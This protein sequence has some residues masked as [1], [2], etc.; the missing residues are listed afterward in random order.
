MIAMTT[1]ISIIVKPCRDVAMA[2]SLVGLETGIIAEFKVRPGG[3]GSA[4]GARECPD[5]RTGQTHAAALMSLYRKRGL[6]NGQER[7]S[8]SGMRHR[9]RH[10]PRG[11]CRR[12]PGGAASTRDRSNRTRSAD[13][14][15]G[16]GRRSAGV[17]SD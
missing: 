12:Q 17:G 5:K 3:N 10:C 2:K 1:A 14:N 15:A 4:S 7:A 11:A 13:P 9:L 8:D 6:S 16:G